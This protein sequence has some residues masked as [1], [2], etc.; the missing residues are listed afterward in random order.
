MFQHGGEIGMYIYFKNDNITGCFRRSKYLQRQ[1]EITSYD[2]LQCMLL[3][4]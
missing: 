4:C 3:F 1:T 2:F